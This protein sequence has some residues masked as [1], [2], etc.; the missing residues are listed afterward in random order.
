MPRDY[1][2]NLEGKTALLNGATTG[3]GPEIA[4]GLA[5]AG[6][7]VYLSD[8]DSSA[9]ACLSSQLENQGLAPAGSFSYQ[10]GTAVAAQGLSYWIK[11]QCS[12]PDIFIEPISGK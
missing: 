1:L 7:L 5:R 11:D 12:A 8:A 10:P 9:L 3:Y 4:A 6:V 2:F